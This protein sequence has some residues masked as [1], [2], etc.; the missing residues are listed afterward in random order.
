VGS[1]RIQLKL[2]EDMKDLLTNITRM[3]NVPYHKVVGA[4][5]YVSMGTCPDITF[6]ISTTVQFMDNLVWVH[7]EAVK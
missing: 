4:L 7:W 1:T 2:V 6:A 3:K 5:M